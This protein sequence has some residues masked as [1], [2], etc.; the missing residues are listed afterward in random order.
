MDMR[1]LIIER[2]GSCHPLQK[3]KELLQKHT[4]LTTVAVLTLLSV[5]F[6]F[7]VTAGLMPVVIEDDGI[8]RTVLTLNRTP[9][10]ILA[11]AG[12]TLAEDDVVT[13]SLDGPDKHICIE[14]AFDVSIT[15]NDGTS[16][17]VRLTGGTVSDALALA[18]V[19]SDAGTVI[20]VSK[21]D[22]VTDGLN[23]CVEQLETTERVT[24]SKVPYMTIV[25]YTDKQPTGS[26]QVVQTG[27]N[28]IKTSRYTDWLQ[29]GEVVRS[30]LASETLTKEP[31]NEII[32]AGT[33]AVT[34][35]APHVALDKN[36]VP[37]HYKTVLTGTA[38]AYTAKPGAITA[39][40]TTPKIGTIAV[41]PKVI[42]YGTKLFV[43]SDDGYVYG[44]GVAEDTG[45]SLMKNAIITDLYMDTVADCYEFGRRTVNVY[46]LE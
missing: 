24:T 25:R 42:P 30:E 22:L 16:T 19:E 18:G 6:L 1:K 14:R 41:N 35:D 44:Y 33:G 9:E 40:G 5:V 46:I 3:G 4:G 37:L 27:V 2:C 17:V 36:G 26:R 21:T 13:S 39:T 8:Q 31:V 45:G 20:N 32:L 43:V 28:G 12:I 10:K 34:E 29:N 23:I 11:G 15:V 7:S 38:C